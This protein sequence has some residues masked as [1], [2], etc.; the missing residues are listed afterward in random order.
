MG[1]GVAVDLGTANTVTYVWGRGVLVDE[2]SAIA[3]NRHDGGIVAVGAAAAIG[4]AHV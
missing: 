4:R 1:L 3:L 2:P